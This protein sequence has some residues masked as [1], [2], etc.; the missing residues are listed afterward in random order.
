MGVVQSGGFTHVILILE[1][2]RQEDCCQFTAVLVNPVSVP[3]RPALLSKTILKKNKT[4]HKRPLRKSQNKTES[5]VPQSKR[6]TNAPLQ[7]AGPLQ[8]LRQ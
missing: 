5:T 2:Q 3:G 4:R 1:K 8:V 7:V 6:Q